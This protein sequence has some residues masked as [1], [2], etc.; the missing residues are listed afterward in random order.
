[1]SIRRLE[2]VIPSVAT[3]DGAGVKLRRSLG[4]SRNQRLD[5]FLML[6]EFGTD[7]PE[8]YIAGFPPHPHRGFETVTYMLDG[9]MRH[10][11][12]LGNVGELK[13]GG[14][15]WMTAGRGIVHSEMPQQEEGRMRGFQLWINLPAKEKMKPASYRDIPAEEI[16]QVALADGGR[17]KVIAGRFEQ[18]GETTAG[19]I[20][21]LSTEPVFVDVELPANGH[22]EHGL[23]E[24]HN[25][26]VYAYEGELQ[27]AG[28]E[29]RPLQRQHAG[30]L[31]KGD[32]VEVGA[33]EDGARF[34]LLAGKP[35]DE[36]VV[37]YGPFVMNTMQEIEQALREYRE[38]TLTGA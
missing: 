34:I 15:Q 24:G 18:D 10:E 9:H 29:P 19:A 3:S 5:P 36:P 14:V 16:P 21:G 6:D 27:I 12:H 20:T 17:V 31:S 32:R 11:D 38:G 33:G 8:D 22:F 7:R 37:Q 28:D 30:I 1:M 13:S 35:I 25:A 2:R 23:P 4:A 26:F